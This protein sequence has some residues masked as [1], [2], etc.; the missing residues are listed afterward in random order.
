MSSVYSEKAI[1]RMNVLSAAYSY[2]NTPAIKLRDLAN[3]F[4]VS[5]DTILNWIDEAL[6]QDLILEASKRIVITEKLDI[7]LKHQQQVTAAAYTYI[8]TPST[9]K[10]LANNFNISEAAFSDYLIEAV[11]QGYIKD[12]DI[13]TLVTKHINE[14]EKRHHLVN[15]SLRTKYKNLLSTI[16]Y[17]KEQQELAG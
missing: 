13:D 11:E 4:T 6:K 10:R 3:S 15:S 16:K 12:E 7:D 9:L 5:V 14:Y 1:H 2:A 17:R 8:K